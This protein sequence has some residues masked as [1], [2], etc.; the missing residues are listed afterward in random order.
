ML[1]KRD[2]FVTP[3]VD[4]PA[5]D[6]A[7]AK[8]PHKQALWLV[9]SPAARWPAAAFAASPDWGSAARWGR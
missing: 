2:S 6:P 3:P 4:N 7:T 8:D 1:Q 9:Y 5:F